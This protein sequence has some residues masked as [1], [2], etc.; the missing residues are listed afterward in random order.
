MSVEYYPLKLE[1]KIKET[2]NSYSFYFSIPKEHQPVFLYRPAQFL[3]FKFSIDGKDCVRSY[4]IS[5]S[6]FLDESL[7]TS[8]KRVE[9]GLVS[10]Y[11]ID[12]LKEG[13]EV[14]SQ[15]PLG[16][17]FT[18]PKTLKQQTYV[19]FAAGIG[20]TPLFSIL[21]T[22]LTIDT[23][24][25]VILIYSN[26]NQRDIIY[27][28]VLEDWRQKY[29]KKLKIH[30]MISQTQGRLDA[31]KICQTLK[32][33]DIATSVFYLCGPKDY[34]KMIEVTLI[35]SQIPNSKIFKEDFNVV[36]IIGPKPDE[37]S[38]IFEAEVFDE[39]EP[40]TLEANIQGENVKISLNREKSL[41]EQLLDQGHNPPFSCVSGSCMTCMAKLKEGKVFQL[42]EG[43]L[44]EDNI[45]AL[46]ILSCQCYP[47][48]KKVI[49][50][51][52]DL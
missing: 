11:M 49:I 3:T 18:P 52:E 35:D 32:E 4:S 43:I 8:V 17:F 51:Y 50:D 31:D 2:Q 33:I 29:P 36:P 42:D 22:V 26:K 45:E 48:S 25:Q 15:K 9:G 46:E 7:Q 6:S 39:G 37:D 1:K 34:M 28:D 12:S 47:L 23:C 41:L 24:K 30:N 38:V 13:D 14:L 10:N 27:K 5:S 40:E 20:V 44:D 21:K 16:E 19:L